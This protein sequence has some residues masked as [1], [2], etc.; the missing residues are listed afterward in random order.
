MLKKLKKLTGVIGGIVLASVL[1]CSPYLYREGMNVSSQEYRNAILREIKEAEGS[2][3]KRRLENKCMLETV[4]EKNPCILALSF[5]EY[6]FYV[7]KFRSRDNK[8]VKYCAWEP[9][10]KSSEEAIVYLN[11]MESNAGW[12]SDCARELVK[13]GISVYGL[14]RRGSGIN[15]EIRGAYNKWI[16]DVDALIKEVKKMREGKAVDVNLMSIC[17]GARIATGEAIKNPRGAKTLIYIS[18]GFNM[19]VDVQPH[20]KMMIGFSSLFGFDIPIK[21]PVK[22]DW[23]FTRE[24]EYTRRI[25][26]DKLRV[27]AP[28]SRDFMQGQILLDYI[29]KNLE[30]VGV[31]SIVFLAGNDEI[32]WPG[33][34]RDTVKE[35][36]YPSEIKEEKEAEHAIFFSNEETRKRFLDDVVRFI[37][38]N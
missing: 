23:M 10:E 20:E 8:E 32:I 21:S 4:I 9:A 3:D 17:F 29:K 18:P 34:T 6:Q 25:G 24:S 35:F 1:G 5:Q 13:K 14:D 38:E 33:A 7:A 28:N 36:C 31:P 15:S 19:K 2:S 26:D 22:S 16:D 37:T 11:G 30:R 12:F 27:R